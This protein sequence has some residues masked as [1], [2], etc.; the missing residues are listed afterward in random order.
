MTEDNQKKIMRWFTITWFILLGLIIAI[1]ILALRSPQTVIKNYVGQKGDS[2]TGPQG[3]IGAVGP[4]GLPGKVEVIETEKVIHETLPGEKGERGEPG[5]Q[6]PTGRSM[7]WS[8][9]PEEGFLT[10]FTGDTFWQVTIPCEEF[11]SKC[12]GE[13]GNVTP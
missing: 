13:D 3:A 9:N 11:V 12:G 1:I 2:I 4:Q 10:R 8:F 7:E 6:G 5:D